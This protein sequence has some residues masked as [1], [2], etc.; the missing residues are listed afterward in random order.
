MDDRLPAGWECKTDA[1][2]RVYYV[3]HINRK[4][5]WECPFADDQSVISRPGSISSIQRSRSRSMEEI[6]REVK[7]LEESSSVCSSAMSETESDL[8]MQAR[9]QPTS[10][11]LENAEI[12]EFAQEILP[13]IVMSR[14][15]KRCFKC[16]GIMTRP[17]MSP[18]HCRSCGEVYCKQCCSFRIEIPLPEDEYDDGMINIIHTLFTV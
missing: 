12:Q 7:N 10:Y 4:T 18:H 15:D 17:N 8:Q 14:S 16:R 6:L 13:H 5:Q 2:G 1:T 9:V 11:F 3:D